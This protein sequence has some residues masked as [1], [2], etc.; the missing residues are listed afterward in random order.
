MVSSVLLAMEV[1]YLFAVRYLDTPSITLRGVMGTPVVLAAV[2]AVLVL[3]TAFTYL[4]WFQG[5]FGTLALPL[6]AL[7]FTVLAGTALL[8]VLELETA[9][10]PRLTSAAG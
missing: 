10:R 4:P 5:T 2:V 3:Q 6:E 9:L 1:F 7:A 8:V